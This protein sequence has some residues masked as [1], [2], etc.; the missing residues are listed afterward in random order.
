VSTYALDAPVDT[1][2]SRERLVALLSAAAARPEVVIRHDVD[3]SPF[4]AAQM[5]E[6]EL[7]HGIR[8]TYHIR[9]DAPDYDLTCDSIPRIVAA[10]HDLGPHVDLHADRGA[11]FSDD[12]LAAACSSAYRALSA[13]YP[14]T[15][16]VSFHQ[17]PRDVIGREVPG[18]ESA[19][20][21]RWQGRWA[22]DS[23][24]IWRINPEELLARG[25]PVMLNLHPEWWFLP[26]EHATAL[27]AREATKP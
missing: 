1:D 14:S 24:G 11:L 18:F 26:D 19:Q 12:E 21:W 20:S 3:Y 6:L 25:G 9:V 16:R 27:R 15:R 2:F 13:A 8:A 5:A 7:E 10:G 17:P 22:A 23:R 4:C